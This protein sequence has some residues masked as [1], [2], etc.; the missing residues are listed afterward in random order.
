MNNKNFLRIFRIVAILEGLSLLI[1]FFI[2]MP[3]KY[4]FGMPQL[5]YSVG[6]AH[7]GLFVAY[8]ILALLG[9]MI[10]RWRV[11]DLVI[12]VIASFIP[13]GTFYVEKKYLKN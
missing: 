3:L 4:W 12:I 2:A 7:G 11:L 9:K 5:I 6:S 8:V 10:E 13:F 1:L